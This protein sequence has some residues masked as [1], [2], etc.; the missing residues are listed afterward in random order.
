MVRHFRL[1]ALSAVAGAVAVTVLAAACSSSSSTGSTPTSTGS[2]SAGQTSGF[3]ALNPG[4]GAPKSGG[5]LNMI[6]VSDVNYMDYDMAYYTLDAMMLRLT[7]RQLY[8]WPAIP[9]KTLTPAPDLATGAPVITNGGK[10]VAVTIRSGIKWNTT[11]PRDVTVADV[12]RGIKRACNP[13]PVAFG[14]MP[15]FESTI[16]GLTAFCQGYPKAA[17]SNAAAL[18]TYVEGTNVPGITTSGNT[19][20]F[21]LIH[22]ASWFEGAMTLP[23]FGAVPIE[24]ENG[25]PGTPAV[26][27][28]MYSDGPY[29]ISAYTP[30]KKLSF[31][32]NPL[33]VASSDPLRKAYVD[34]VNVDETGDQ[35]VIYQQISTNSPSLAMTWD[36]LPPPADD[37]DLLAQV[38][39]GSKDVN[40]GP[41]YGSN[42]YLV[43]NT[44]S[45]NDGGA[46]S[47]PAVRQALFF[48]LQR[49]QLIKVNGG[50]VIAPPLTH[51]LPAGT[52]G[53][54]DVPANYDPYPYNPDKA[55]SMLTAAGFSPANKLT[56]KYLYRSDS[57]GSTKTYLNTQSQLNALGMVNVVGVPTTH[58]DFYGKYLQNPTSPTPA[59]KGVWDMAQAGW[60]P[61]W[62]GNG[63]LTWFNPLFLAPESYPVNGGSN[64]G[65][66]N[67]PTVNNLIKQA[68]AQPNEAQADQFW[69]KA[70][71]A[72][73]NGAAIYPITSDNQL[74]VHASYVHN[75]VYM[76]QYQQFDPANVWLSAPGSS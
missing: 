24:A 23:P 75:A 33:W 30:A 32:R 9:G 74:L 14:G 52:A 15:D 66:F 20:T 39:A 13:S 57:Q 46:L 67:D 11:P 37:Q 72:V 65:L 73:M 12:V 60:G 28:H 29:Q 7:V 76:P 2:A 21:T 19:I 49:S 51:I 10:T 55:K 61:D 54:Q 40:L 26:Y 68:Q 3:Q 16:Q 25:L 63:T 1:R 45:P 50:P 31:T 64:Y 22:P 43:F 58:A 71:M 42:P 48:G 70:D 47:K 4:T 34:A 35:S 36:S 53:A 41:S 44:I 62:Y 18:K 6:G 38:K 56:L 17:A 27:S 8:G 59:A 69:A 5:T